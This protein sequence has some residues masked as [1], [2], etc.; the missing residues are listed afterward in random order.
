LILTK[1]FARTALRKVLESLAVLQTT[2]HAESANTREHL[3]F[4]DVQIGGEQE[5]SV[6]P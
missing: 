4:V 2:P 6:P 5:T 3:G 1:L